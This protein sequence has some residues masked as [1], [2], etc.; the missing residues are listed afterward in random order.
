MSLWYYRYMQLQNVGTMLSPS[1]C[2]YSCN[3]RYMFQR[4]ITQIFWRHKMCVSFYLKGDNCKFLLFVWSL[5]FI[6]LNKLTSLCFSY[7]P[8]I[9]DLKSTLRRM[10]Y[11]PIG[12]T[13]FW[14]RNNPAISCNISLLQ[15]VLCRYADEYTRGRHIQDLLNTSSTGPVYIRDTNIVLTA[16]AYVLAPNGARSSPDT[17]L[18]TILHIL[19]N[20]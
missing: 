14:T 18:T 12:K 19:S 16:H 17:M 9:A 7:W 5:Q 11:I 20:F 10:E 2:Q 13:Y 1:V 4:W 3:C 6:K 15:S 8:L